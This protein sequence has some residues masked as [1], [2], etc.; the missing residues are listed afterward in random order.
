MILVDTSVWIDHL[1]RAVP[2]LVDALEA[3]DVASHPFV[4]GEL[5]CGTLKR[6]REVLSLL[7]ALPATALATNEEALQLIESHDLMGR[8]I[9]LVDVHLI[10]SVMLT[11]D[12]TLWTRDKRLRPVVERLAIAFAGR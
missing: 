10:A 5:A 9:G 4:I 7:G 1:H 12:C 8:G 3:A 11:P 2:G 6:R